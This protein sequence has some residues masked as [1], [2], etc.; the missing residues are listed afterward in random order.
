MWKNSLEYFN[1]VI[2]FQQIAK[3]TQAKWIHAL[4]SLGNKKISYL[5][6]E[7]IRYGSRRT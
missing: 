4:K 3:Q 7:R 5:Y 1:T 6:E 2:C